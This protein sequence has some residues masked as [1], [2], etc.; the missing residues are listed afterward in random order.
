MGKSFGLTIAFALFSGSILSGCARNYVDTYQPV[1]DMKGVDQTAFENDL[2][3]C[4]QYAVNE[5]PA[6]KAAEGAIAGALVGAALGAAVGSAYGD[7]DYG[8]KVGAAEG[9]ASGTVGGAVTGVQAQ[10]AIVSR[11]LAG[12]GYNVLYAGS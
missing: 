11:C 10:R 7:T 2:K 9:A 4:R 1:I 5:D 8:V 3:E 6:T 12:R